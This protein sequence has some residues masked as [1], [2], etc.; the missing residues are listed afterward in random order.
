M[1]SFFK[2]LK[3]LRELSSFTQRQMAEKLGIS[4]TQYQ[5]YEDGTLPPHEKVLKLNSI[6]DYDL[7]RHI[8]QL[9]VGSEQKYLVLEE[10][11]AEY[12]ANHKIEN[13][14]LKKRVDDLERIVS[15]QEDLL[16]NQKKE[17]LPLKRERS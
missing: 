6:F 15:L 3:E 11:P 17:I 16:K 5:K 1:E 7:S 2:K 12:V 13:E 10:P 4:T 9:K 8:Y 14:Y